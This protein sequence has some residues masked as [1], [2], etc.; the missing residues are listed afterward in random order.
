MDRELNI[1]T[2]T[3]EKNNEITE[4]MKELENSLEDKKLNNKIEAYST[5][6]DEVLNEVEYAHKYKGKLNKII[7]ECMKEESY[8]GDFWYINYDKTKNAYSMELYRDG[9][10]QKFSI[11]AQDVK[12]YNYKVGMTY[13]FFEDGTMLE[14]DA[15]KDSIKIDVDS[16]IADL[17]REKRKK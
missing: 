10:R 3:K 9:E 13:W 7:T 5:I 16:A 17:E 8:E 2:N 15:I 14:E 11:T 4:F 12:K 1:E 6:Y